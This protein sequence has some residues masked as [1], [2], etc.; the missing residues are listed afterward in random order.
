VV[1][2]SSA[3][4]FGGGKIARGICDHRHEEPGYK[5]SRKLR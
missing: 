4:T 2:A 3:G 5:P 1:R